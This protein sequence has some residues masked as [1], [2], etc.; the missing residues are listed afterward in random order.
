MTRVQQRTWLRRRLNETTADQWSDVSLNDY[1]NE[2]LHFMQQEIE[3]IDPEAFVYEDSANIVA[4]QRKYAWPANMKREVVLEAKFTAAATEYTKLSRV[5]LRKCDNPDTGQEYT[6]AHHGRYLK[7]QATPTVAVP[8]GLWLTYVPTLSMGD[9]ADVPDIPVDVHMGIVLMAQL[10]AF[11]DSS[12]TAD[13]EEV[14]KELADV[15]LRLPMH[16]LKSGAEPD[17]FVVSSHYR[18]EPGDMD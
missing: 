14:R 15:I 12:G 16:Y 11:G 13:K 9:D 1:L 8:A 3:K 6:Y 7:L 5:G 10:V 17:K 2:G 18:M 4:D